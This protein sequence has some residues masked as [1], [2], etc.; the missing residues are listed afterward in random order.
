MDMTS[1]TALD[2]AFD[3]LLEA[4]AELREA[5]RSAGEV[6]ENRLAGEAGVLAGAVEAEV[7]A[8]HA[9]IRRAE[10]RL[11]YKLAGQAAASDRGSAPR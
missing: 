9:V 8:T 5:E 10:G 6:G 11:L 1:I 3:R 7:D 4:A 2:R